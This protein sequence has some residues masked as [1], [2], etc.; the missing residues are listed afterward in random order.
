LDRASVWSVALVFTATTA[1]SFQTVWW[2]WHPVRELEG[3]A[4]WDL[5]AIV[6]SAAG[7]KAWVRWLLVGG[8]A[9]VAL[10]ATGVIMQRAWGFLLALPCSASLIVCTL[11]ARYAAIFSEPRQ[12]V[13][14]SHYVQAATVVALVTLVSHGAA[15]ML[16]VRLLCGRPVRLVLARLTLAALAVLVAGLPGLWIHQHLPGGTRNAVMVCACAAAAL[17]A[18]IACCLPRRGAVLASIGVSI[19]ALA[20]LAVGLMLHLHDRPRRGGLYSRAGE[21]AIGEVVVAAPLVLALIA[22]CIVLRYHLAGT[23]GREATGQ[24]TSSDPMT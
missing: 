19:T 22:I 24:G 16:G 3:H 5:L 2:S 4:T 13:S 23:H 11:L 12:Y 15:M 1:V 9:L 6:V 14:R 8:A 20:V 18:L 7:L 21:Q 10:A 17:A